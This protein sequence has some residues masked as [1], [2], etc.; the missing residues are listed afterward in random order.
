[1]GTPNID[2]Y[3][4][5]YEDWLA[6]NTESLSD[7]DRRALGY[8][9]KLVPLATTHYYYDVETPIEANFGKPFD[10][11]VKL[12][13]LDPQSSFATSGYIFKAATS[14]FDF[15]I[16]LNPKST[17]VSLI[18]EA[19]CLDQ[20]APS[21]D[22]GFVR[23]P[24]I[25]YAYNTSGHGG[26]NPNIPQ[27][28]Q[29]QY[30]RLAFDITYNAYCVT[31]RTIVIDTNLHTATGKYI[32]AY[33][34]REALADYIDADPDNRWAGY[35][36]PELYYGNNEERYSIRNYAPHDIYYVNNYMSF[37][38]FDTYSD[39]PVPENTILR[40][41]IKDGNDSWIDNKIFSPF[42][43]MPAQ[44]SATWFG[45]SGNVYDAGYQLTIGFTRKA[46]RN[47][48]RNGLNY[49]PRTSTKI[50]GEWLRCN[51]N[52]KYFDD[53]VYHWEFCIYDEDL[54][55][56]IPLGSDINSIPNNDVIRLF[57]KLCIDDYKGN[58][59]GKATELAI[60]HEV[61]Y[62]GLYIGD[63]P[64]QASTKELG[65]DSDGIGIYLPKRE[66]GIPNGEFY[67]G[68]EIKD[69]PY[70]DAEST[71]NFLDES[72]NALSNTSPDL[73]NISIK[74]IFKSGTMYT[75]I[76]FGK[77]LEAI[78][79]IPA[80]LEHDILATDE[81][82]FGADPYDFMIGYFKVPIIFMP[83]YYINNII[84][85]QATIFEWIHM[86]KWTT[87]MLSD[88]SKWTGGYK[89][90][91]TAPLRKIFVQPTYIPRHFNNFL[92]YEPYTTMSLYLPY[93]GT[94][95]LPPSLF[96][97]H[98]IMILT[99]LDLLSGRVTYLI[100]CDGIQFNSVSCNC[101]LEMP[102]TG[103]DISSYTENIIRG[104]QEMINTAFNTAGRIASIATVGA[105]SSA[106]SEKK[107]NPKAMIA[108]TIGT[109]VTGAITAGGAVVNEIFMYRN[110]KRTQPTPQT[111]SMGGVVE[112][113]G[114]IFQPF[115][116][117]NFPEYIT[118]FKTE[119]YG[120]INGFACYDNAPLSNYKGFTIME[121]PILD[122]L[123][124]SAEEKEMIRKLLA[125]G[126][127]LP[128]E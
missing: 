59:K 76:D 93:Y 32:Q 65:T 52:K 103:T 57:T 117:F 10:E 107:D 112:G 14:K 115:I 63:T 75:N 12:W 120:K 27:T 18:M 47:E 6:A 119:E 38:V 30:G 23:D 114:N 71:K 9:A 89:A 67:T 64:I 17:P 3:G 82:F 78:N 104:R 90:E 97:G 24:S 68:A 29:D 74:D 39:R 56:E 81:Y 73:L 123:N 45:S 110:M 128:Y 51:F 16:N 99:L 53:V 116:T 105:A 96:V 31:P 125:E 111:I 20:A 36:R 26:D 50:Y 7:P 83:E 127:I 84:D 108:R 70:A 54:N 60:L 44:D 69:I 48:W 77:L 106:I 13:E 40:N 15:D 1:M 46:R 122:N 101:R 55:I 49:I 94:L 62:I 58:S 85:N 21:V 35:I 11:S 79:S 109:K 86:G 28:T 88:V 126:V 22:V 98:E 2:Y 34:N 124:I 37:P 61:S 91:L 102:I 92:D 100:Y 95:E 8:V 66:S 42:I 4:V 118:G 5:G 72:N 113:Y 41:Y 121:N 19:K 87:D 43:P 25:R 80:T 33:D